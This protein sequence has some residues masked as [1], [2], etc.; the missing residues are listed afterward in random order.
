M[1][2]HTFWLCFV[3]LFIATDAIGAVP[4]FISLTQGIEEK[5]EKVKLISLSLITAGVVGMLFLFVGEKVFTLLGITTADFM[6]AGG[7]MLFV[8]SLGDLVV[9]EKPTRKF[10]PEDIGPVPVGVPLIVGPGVLT[11]VMLL[12]KQ[13]GFWHTGVALAAN[14]IIAGIVFYFHTIIIKIFG[15]NGTK[16]ISKIASLFLAAIAVM[17][18][19]KGII[20]IIQQ[21]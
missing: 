11:T 20:S 4:V 19:R 6:V 5:K 15:K 2:A 13:Y 10:H 14:I 17:I 18:I 8:I 3:P 16:I 9:V 21:V 1:E 7:I 12:V